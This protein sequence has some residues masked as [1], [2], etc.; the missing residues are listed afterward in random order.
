MED[1][2]VIGRIYEYRHTPAEYRWFWSVT[3]FHLDPAL[4]ITTNDGVPTLED[5]KARFREAW[6]K[7]REASEQKQP[8]Q[9]RD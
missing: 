5:A 9:D 3:A 2:K 1:G 4:G 7:V 6:S 8:P